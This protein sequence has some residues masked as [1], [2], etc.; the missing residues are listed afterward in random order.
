MCWWG[1]WDWAATGYFTC[2]YAN[3]VDPDRPWT[4]SDALFH[5][6]VAMKN[7]RLI[8]FQ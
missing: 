4:S 3:A 2:V 7:F 5:E 8:A 1:L 6:H